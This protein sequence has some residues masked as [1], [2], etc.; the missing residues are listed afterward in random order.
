MLRARG[1]K[2][3]VAAIPLTNQPERLT[4]V[5]VNGASME[6]ERVWMHGEHLIFKFK[7]VDSITD[8]ERLA[9]LDVS[10]PM[11]QRA[12]IAEGEYYQSDLVGCDVLDE[13]GRP[14]GTVEGWQETGGPL[15]VAV[16]T[17]SG[18]ELLIPFANSIFTK[19]D[20]ERRRIVVTLPEGLLDLN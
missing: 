10:I 19:I 12:V 6:V 14:I 2:G 20:L 13:T 5:I 3:E 17:A 4:S 7:G 18:K 9:G 11:E 1:N 8:A 16:R 15:L